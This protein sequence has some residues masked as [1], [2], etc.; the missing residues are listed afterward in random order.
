MSDFAVVIKYQFEGEQVNSVVLDAVQDVGVNSNTTITTQPIVNGDE[1]SDHQFKEPKTL[2][3]RGTCSLN[4]SQATIIDGS[5]SKLANFEELFERIQ[6]EGIACDI[7]KIKINNEKDIRFLQRTNMVLESISWNERINSID[8]TLNFRQVI[9]ADVVSYEV[10]LA[11][12]YLPKIT[13][14][15]TLSFTNTL[16]DWEQID[17]TIIKIMEEQELISEDFKNFVSSSDIAKFAIGVGG[18]IAIG[19]IA[20]ALNTTPVGW[21]ITAGVL[22]VAGF[23]YL[24]KGIRDAIKRAKDLKKYAVQRFEYY[25][26]PEKDEAEVK[27]FIEFIDGL[28]SEIRKIDNA[29]HIYQ[30][31]INEPQEA[32]ISIGSEYYIFTFTQNN[33]NGKYSLNIENQDKSKTEVVSDITASPT[34]IGQL[35]SKALIQAENNARIYLVCPSE[36]KDDLR[37]YYVLVCDFNPEEFN[38]IIEKIVISKIYKNAGVV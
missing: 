21:V 19:L 38:E 13:E 34:D 11:D 33:I 2:S 17:A 14:P 24:I 8:F 16:L 37:N 1:I 35:S 32:L 20:A 18:G 22:V 27:R 25:N 30:I 36:D 9:V 28:E 3:I 12:K 31:S 23:Y 10:D 26:N 15:N 6:S 29:I 5:G 7:F 4:G